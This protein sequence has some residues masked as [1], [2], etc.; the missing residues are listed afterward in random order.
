[1]NNT[2]RTVNRTCKTCSRLTDNGRCR[3][4]LILVK[5]CIEHHLSYWKD[6]FTADEE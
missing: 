6:K 3:L 4:E 2:D 1:M 5:D